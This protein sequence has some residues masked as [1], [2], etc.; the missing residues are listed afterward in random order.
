MFPHPGTRIAHPT[1]GCHPPSGRVLEASANE[2]AK[3][4][5]E[6][7]ALRSS[8]PYWSVQKE[9]GEGGGIGT[10]EKKGTAAG[11]EKQSEL[12]CGS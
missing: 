7:R 10:G 2:K 9:V 8:N 6:G 12:C 1:N 11:G 5:A 4:R 3:K